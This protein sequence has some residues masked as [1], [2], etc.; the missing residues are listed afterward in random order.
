MSIENQPTSEYSSLD[1]Q[2]EQLMDSAVIVPTVQAKTLPSTVQ[3]TAP[4]DLAEGYEFTVEVD[5]KPTVIRVPAGG[6]KEG[7]IFTA[8]IVHQLANS[9]HKI[10]QGEWRN[11]I[12]D[13]FK[14]GFCHPMCCLAFWCQPLALGQVMTRMRLNATGR[15]SNCRECVSLSSAINDDNNLNDDLDTEKGESSQQP[16]FW[17]AFKVLAVVLASYIALDQ[18]INILI[19]PYPEY[20]TDDG[21]NVYVLAVPVWVNVM[22][23]LQYALELGFFLYM[24]YLIICTRSYI[25]ARYNI[26]EGRC[27]G[28]EDCCCA[29]WLP[30]CTIAQMARHTADYSQYPAAC[31][32]DTGLPEHAPM[33]V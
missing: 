12:C 33:I 19:T 5:G 4:I 6:V 1:K 22:I 32:T 23:A 24:L 30:F 29:F 2:G 31:C 3:V 21:G 28:C 13:C 26:P 7:Q 9:D 16:Q 27:R 10:P 25:R 8:E 17:T 20:V 18:M 11:G 15:V 14:N